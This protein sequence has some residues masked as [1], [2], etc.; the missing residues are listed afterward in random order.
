[1]FVTTAYPFSETRTR[2]RNNRKAP[3]EI[4]PDP[5]QTELCRRNIK[6]IF[7]FWALPNT[8]AAQVVEIFLFWKT[9]TA[10]PYN[11]AMSNCCV[12]A[13]QGARASA[14]MVLTHLSQ[15]IPTLAPEELHLTHSGRG[16]M[17]AILH[18]PPFQIHF[19][20]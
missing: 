4:R 3:F 1:M 10:V 11:P 7:A 6:C 16:K 14:A 5:L 18:W 19:L 20:E 8:K 15:N 13:T 2:G 12:L 9:R 17:V